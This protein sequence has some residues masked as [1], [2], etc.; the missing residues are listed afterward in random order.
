M[1]CEEA[2]IDPHQVPAYVPD[3]NESLADKALY[4]HVL[5]LIQDVTDGLENYRLSET[6]EKIVWLCMGLFL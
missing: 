3:G 1:Q 5:Q 6:G 4:S 2:G